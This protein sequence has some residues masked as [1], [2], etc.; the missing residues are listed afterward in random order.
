MNEDRDAYIGSRDYILERSWVT[1]LWMRVI[2]K[3][4]DDLALFIRMEEDGE[5]I[6]EEEWAYGETA[7]GFLFDPHYV[8]DLAGKG[9]TLE[10]LL[11]N[12]GCHDIKGWRE[13]TRERILLLV[14]EKRKALYTRRSKEYANRR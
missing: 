11:E 8:I 10:E 4:I 13:M 6:S 1:E 14:K 9:A 3:A 7:H 12:W 5:K 2:Q